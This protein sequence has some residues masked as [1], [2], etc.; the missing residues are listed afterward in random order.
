MLKRE[1]SIYYAAIYLKYQLE[2]YPT[3]L[4]CAISGYNAGRC[5]KSNQKTYVDKVLRRLAVLDER[6]SG[7]K[8][9]PSYNPASNGIMIYRPVEIQPVIMRRR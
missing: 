1:V 7:K 3:D 6:S 4:R 2:R 9:N 5:I 8:L